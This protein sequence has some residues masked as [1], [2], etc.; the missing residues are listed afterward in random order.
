MNSVGRLQGKV[1]IVT[2]SG[3]GIGRGI[4][5]AFGRAGA[6]VV[7]A[8]RTASTVSSVVQEIKEAGGTALGFPCDVG[9]REEVFALVA[10][11]VDRF[12]PV[13]ILVNA[14]QSVGTKNDPG[15]VAIPSPLETCD[16]GEW[17]HIFRTGVMA[18]LWAMKA[19]FPYMKTRGGKI[20]NFGSFAGRVGYAGTA[21][22]NANKEGIIGLSRTAARE[23]GKYSINVNIINPFIKTETTETHFASASPEEAAAFIAAIPMKRFGTL[24]DVGALAVFLASAESDYITGATL[25]LDGGVNDLG[26]TLLDGSS[27]LDTQRD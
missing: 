16:E 15:V 9:E 18:T 23:W 24:D 5:L 1:A 14:A 12:G 8:S 4:A 22:Y 11:A 19:A 17:E 26:S 25:M 10:A 27:Y 2:G 3:R 20:I 6:A 13:D 7:V 21:A